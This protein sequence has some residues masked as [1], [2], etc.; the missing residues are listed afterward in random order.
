MPFKNKQTKALRIVYCFLYFSKSKQCKIVLLITVWHDN[1]YCAS[2]FAT[3]SLRLYKI[4]VILN[5]HEFVQKN[6]QFFIECKKNRFEIIIESHTRVH[7]EMLSSI[8]KHTFNVFVFVFICEL[9]QHIKTLVLFLPL[10]FVSLYDIFTCCLLFSFPLSIRCH[11]ICVMFCVS[12]QLHSRYF[13]LNILFWPYLSR[14]KIKKT[15]KTSIN[16]DR[17]HLTEIGGFMFH[18]YASVFTFSCSPNSIPCFFLFRFQWSIE[19]RK[20]NT[21]TMY[22]HLH[23]KLLFFRIE[24]QNSMRANDSR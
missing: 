17:I 11:V 8:V 9:K 15:H 14:N 22:W 1:S 3:I 18:L 7:M 20:V 12:V 10:L 5:L 2:L 19:I 13:T 23:E 21:A 6:Q 16:I 24:N 4:E